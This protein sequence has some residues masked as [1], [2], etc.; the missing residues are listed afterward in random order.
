VV[1]VFQKNSI[2]IEIVLG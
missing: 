1:H 2:D